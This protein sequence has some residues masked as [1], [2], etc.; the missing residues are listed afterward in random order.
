RN[1]VMAERIAALI[2]QQPTFVA[3]GAA[4]WGGGKGVLRGL[5]QKGFKISPAT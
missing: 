1:Q 5:K 2:R 4:H 3:I